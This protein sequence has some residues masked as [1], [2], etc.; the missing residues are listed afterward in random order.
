VTECLRTAMPTANFGVPLAGRHCGTAQLAHSIRTTTI[1]KPL[2]VWSYRLRRNNVRHTVCRSTSAVP[3]PQGKAH[4]CAKTHRKRDAAEERTGRAHAA[5][6]SAGRGDNRSGR[7]IGPVGR[8]GRP[9]K[10][11]WLCF[12][13]TLCVLSSYYRL[14]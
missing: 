13:R 8:S 5:A 14:R 3:L 2:W 4:Q 12:L 7:R 10:R 1:S 6:Q 9:I 11:Q